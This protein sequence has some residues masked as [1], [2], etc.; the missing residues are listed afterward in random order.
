LNLPGHVLRFTLYAFVLSALAVLTFPSLRNLYFNPAYFRDDYRQLAADIQAARCPEDA[1]VLNAPNQWEVFTYYAPD[2]DVYPAP[3]HPSAGKA[4]RFLTPILEAYERIFAVYWGDAESDPRKQ[5]ETWLAEHAYKTGD[6][7]YG[8][9]RLAIYDVAP[10]PEEPQV[11]L[12]A[13]FGDSAGG[14]PAGGDTGILLHGYALAERGPFFPGDVIPVTLFWQAESLI[15]EPYKVTIQLLDDGGNLSAQI[16]TVPRD[17][18]APT[19]SWE[20]GRVLTDRYGL[21]LPPEL[22][23]GRYSLIVAVYHAATGERLSVAVGGE[24]VGDYLA[25]RD[26]TVEDR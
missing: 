11:T 6:R 4:G 12:E 10:L 5:I 16:D 13:R 1:V 7:W 17:G 26:V 19:R 21:R 9:V 15:E 25:L 18:L 14:A 24:A 20:A 3:Y 2:E 22:L 8:D 23:P